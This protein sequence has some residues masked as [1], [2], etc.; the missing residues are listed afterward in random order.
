MDKGLVIILFISVT[1][2]LIFLF[3]FVYYY[4]MSITK[5]QGETNG[6]NFPGL[7]PEEVEILSC[8]PME[9]ATD[10]VTGIKRCPNDIN[11]V[12]LP[13]ASEVCNPRDACT[14]NL[15]PYAVNTDDSTNSTGICSE[16]YVC[17]CLAGPQCANYI[18]TSFTTNN[19]NPYTDLPGQQIFF[20]QT[21]STP[22]IKVDNTDTFCTIP[23]NFLFN[24]S[25]GCNFTTT[26]SMQTLDVCMNQVNTCQLGAPAFITDNY[27]FDPNTD[28]IDTPVACVR[29]DNVCSS[30]TIPV[31][32]TKYGSM[33]CIPY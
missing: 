10:L 32:N 6:T 13:T 27:N 17:P 18:L 14:N 2:M 20:N 28:Y 16:G 12:V 11:Q 9:C 3:L 15:T 7:T 4:I 22:P 24:S 1:I 8:A 23:A 26:L 21:T 31:F 25:P 5:S 30:G 33:V 19:G 29:G